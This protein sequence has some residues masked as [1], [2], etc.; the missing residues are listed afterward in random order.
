MGKIRKALPSAIYLIL[1]AAFFWQTFSIR[2]TDNIGLIS[3]TTVPRAIILMLVIAA[4]IN[5][6]HDLHGEEPERFIHIPWKFLVTAL[7]LLFAAQY[8]KKIG[9]VII[10]SLFL[11]IMFNL[12]DDP[13]M[14]TTKRV[15][16]QIG[17][18]IVLSII[19]CYAFRYGLKVR[20][21]LWPKF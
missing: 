16:L 5:L 10:G 11:G 1:A 19:I 4:V 18:G 17:L 8:C 9:F 13:N 7:L 15:L 3:A 21:P 12:L 2:K 6:F 20:L 14:R